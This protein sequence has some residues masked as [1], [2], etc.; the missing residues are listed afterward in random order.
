MGRGGPRRAWSLD[1]WAQENESGFHAPARPD[2]EDD[3][4]SGQLPDGVEHYRE[5]VGHDGSETQGT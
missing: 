3:A 1:A 4:P 2:T 5:I